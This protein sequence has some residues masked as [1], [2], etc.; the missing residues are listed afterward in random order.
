MARRPEH[1]NRDERPGGDRKLSAIMEEMARRLLKE[2]E[3]VPSAA[4]AQM[5][6]MLAASAWNFACGDAAM[7]EKRLELIKEF[8]RAGA[9]PWPELLPGDPDDLIASLVAYKQTRYPHDRRRIVAAGMGPDGT[10]RVHWVDGNTPVKAAFG[11][12]AAPALAGGTP[13]AD[14]LIAKMKR[15]VHGGVVKL[16]EV[17][18]GR[19]IA[20]EMQRSVVTMEGLAEYHP[21]HAAYIYAQN[22]MSVMSQQL[23]ALRE[24]APLADIVEKA[25]EMYLPSG[26]PMSPLTASY[27]TCWAFFDA[28]IG[29]AN[30]T[31]G[32]T[33]IKAGAAFGMHPDLVRVLQLMQDS[34]MGLY[35]LD[36]T[37]G[38]RAMLRDLGSDTVCGA[39]VPSGYRGQKGEIWFVRVL[40][41]P[42]PGGTEH[43]VFTTPYVVLSPGL[44]EWLAYFGRSIPDAPREARLEVLH[45]HMKYGPTRNYWNDFVLEAYVNHRADVIY[46][47]GLPDRP[48]TRP[49]SM[50]S[51]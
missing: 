42:L 5:A 34:T 2:P 51:R 30:E 4:A 21:A 18:K 45:H 44:P 10:I 3:G 16:K 19:A 41:P 24:L 27:F 17:I 31:I 37:Q 22:Q 32:T 20:Q 47:T 9:M 25:E 26:P 39:I 36:G 49:H 43:V 23:T 38:D 46:L 7:R 12:P 6:L 13:I 29:P 40:P 1:G 33:A 11:T 50:V 48:E 8:E 28:C 14:K 35:V 15:H